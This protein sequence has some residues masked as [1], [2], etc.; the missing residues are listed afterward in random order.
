MGGRSAVWINFGVGE[1]DRGALF[2]LESRGV[3]PDEA[4]ALL[5]RAF[6]ADA[7]ERIGEK[8]VREAFYADAEGWF[9]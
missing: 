8:K 2:Y 3:S 6:V 7:L 1:L 4:K 5:T 9:A